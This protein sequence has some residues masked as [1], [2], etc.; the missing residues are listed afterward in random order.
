MDD[1]KAGK[2]KE[3]GAGAP[4]TDARSSFSTTRSDSGTADQDLPTLMPITMRPDLSDHD[5]IEAAVPGREFDAELGDLD[6]SLR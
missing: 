1:E 4:G 5:H 3:S 2:E 6:V